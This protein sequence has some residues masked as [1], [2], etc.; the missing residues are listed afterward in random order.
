MQ[1]TKTSDFTMLV[2]EIQYIA[3]YKRKRQAQRSLPLDV[4]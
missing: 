2:S 3:N 1:I 4:N